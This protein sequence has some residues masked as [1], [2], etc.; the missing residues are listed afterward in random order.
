MLHTSR[1][2]TRLPRKE[3]VKK[4]KETKGFVAIKKA[5][6]EKAMAAFVEETMKDPEGKRILEEEAKEHEEAMKEVK[7]VK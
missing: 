3:S 1:G 6:I 4:P 7:E 2:D 5:T